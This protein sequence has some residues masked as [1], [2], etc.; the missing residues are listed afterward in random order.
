VGRRSIEE[1]PKNSTMPVVASMVEDPS[2]RGA[3]EAFHAAGARLVAVPVHDDGPDVGHLAR[4]LHT[5][6]PRLVYYQPVVHNPTGVSMNAD[7]RREL[8]AVADHHGLVTIADMSSADLTFDGH[9]GRTWGDA[10][11]AGGAAAL[12]IGTTSKLFWGGLRIG[13]VR[14]DLPTISRLTEAKKAI[15]LA[16]AVLDQ[17]VAADLI[18][19]SDDARSQRAR[20]LRLGLRC[21]EHTLL[22]RRPTWRWPSPTGGT[23][24]WI[25]TGE[26]T[27]T[28]AERGR[29]HGVRLAAGPAFSAHGAFRRHLR[30]PVWHPRDDLNEALDR[31]DNGP[32]SPA[33]RG[34]GG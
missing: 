9:G 6:R 26:D 2:Y 31:L 3:L 18:A 11:A 21:T 5:R 22:A 33:P 16:V 30:L 23:G 19:H 15:D 1:A 20:K 14:G 28:L 8:A 10:S 24:L 27:V 7:A 32:R 4:I 25:D 17:I 13:W 34:A 29:R 12:T